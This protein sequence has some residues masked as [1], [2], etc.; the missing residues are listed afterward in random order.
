[1]IE[2][3]EKA[4]PFS[5]FVLI[6]HG[7]KTTHSAWL[8]ADVDAKGNELS[9]GVGEQ[10]T[11]RDYLK[12]K[13]CV[14]GVCCFGSTTLAEAIVA[15]DGAI[16]V[17]ASKPQNTLTGQDVATAA[18]SLL[19]A[20]EDVK[21]SSITLELLV[22]LCVPKIDSSVLSRFEQFSPQAKNGS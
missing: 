15:H 4:K 6:A 12:D 7:D 16:F 5:V 18:T 21:P 20:M 9:L 10:S 8:C 1:L 11:L 2:V 17:L 22:R 19:G 14:F 13:V 3:L